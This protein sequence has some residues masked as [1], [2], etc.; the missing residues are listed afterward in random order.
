M[1]GFQFVLVAVAAA[2]P[3]SLKH[4]LHEKRDVPASD[5]VKSGRVEADAILPMRIGLTQ[6]NLDNGYDYLMDV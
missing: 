5:W 2:V 6:T 1:F 4:V 3:A